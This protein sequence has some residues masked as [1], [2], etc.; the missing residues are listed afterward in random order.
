MPRPETNKL[1]RKRRSS[2]NE[3]GRRQPP[4]NYRH[5]Q[6]GPFSHDSQHES[7]YH[8]DQAQSRPSTFSTE[9]TTPATST[10]LQQAAIQEWILEQES[11]IEQR[12]TLDQSTM[13]PPSSVTTLAPAP[14]PAPVVAAATSSIWHVTPRSLAHVEGF[15]CWMD[16][17]TLI[18]RTNGWHDH[19]KSR[20]DD[21]G[22]DPSIDAALNL[23]LYTTV[24][25]TI[26]QDLKARGWTRNLRPTETL[27]MIVRLLTEEKDEGRSSCPSSKRSNSWNPATSH[28]SSPSYADCGFCMKGTTGTST[29]SGI[30]SCPRSGTR[31]RHGMIS[32]RECGGGMGLLFGRN[33]S[34]SC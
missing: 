12:L 14:A 1:T 13:G 16:R 7:S 4:L 25:G 3:D 5:M 15:D 17:I 30:L 28:R 26:A 22:R 27:V 6:T 9:P 34:S 29:P 18:A 2:S 23:L 10:M 19:L 31:T 32:G 21:E 24:S 8:D 11:M 20:R 33:L